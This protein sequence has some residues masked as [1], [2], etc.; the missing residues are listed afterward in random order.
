M[1]ETTFTISSLVTVLEKIQKA[2]GD[3]PITVCNMCYEY[4]IEQVKISPKDEYGE[5]RV[6]FLVLWR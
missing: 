1:R 3:L 2:H 6:I 4:P 5:D